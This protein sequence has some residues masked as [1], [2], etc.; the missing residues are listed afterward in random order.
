[1][2]DR[3]DQLATLFVHRAH[4]AQTGP[5]DGGS[6]IG[7]VAGNDK[8]LVWPSG[9]LPVMVHHP[10]LGIVRLRPGI[11]EGHMVKALRQDRRDLGCQFDRR[12]MGCLEE[13]VVKRQ[14]L[15]LAI[16]DIG[17]FIAPIANI[18]APQARHAV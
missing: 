6:V 7:I 17:Q 10:Q 11:G 4:A 14:F 2:V 15:H 13:C 3:R 1:M 9:A 18:H 16:G 8:A 5:G 12:R